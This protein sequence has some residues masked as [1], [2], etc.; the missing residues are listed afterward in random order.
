MSMTFWV[1][2]K[3]TVDNLVSYS[4]VQDAPELNCSNLNATMVIRHLG[5]EVAPD[6][7][8]F[9]FEPCDLMSRCEAA[10]A[11]LR[12]IPFPD[13]AIPGGLIVDALTTPELCG[14]REGYLRDVIAEILRIAQYAFLLGGEKLILV[15]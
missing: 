11:A 15:G 7:Y 4:E 8:T 2:E 5:Y 3:R 1:A 10:L 9:R 14:I 13:S 12:P 6:E